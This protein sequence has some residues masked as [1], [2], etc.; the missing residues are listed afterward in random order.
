MSSTLAQKKAIV[1]HELG[2]IRKI[3]KRQYPDAIFQ[4][5]EGP[6]PSPRSLWMRVFTDM[7]DSET[8]TDLI[9][10]RD[11]ELLEK[12]R[13][14]LIVHARPLA[15]L[16]EPRARRASNGTRVARE[17]RATYRVK[18]SRRKEPASS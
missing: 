5:L 2:E 9:I 11:L 12:K 16:P 15:Y 10:E 17:R 7:V 6:E 4:V 13:F 18:R 1:H 8:L 14:L 3:I